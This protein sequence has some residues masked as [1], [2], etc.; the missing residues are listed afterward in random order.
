MSIETPPPVPPYQAN[1]YAAPAPSND[2]Y[3]VLAIVSLVTAFFVSLAA[4]IT[5]HIALSQIKKT[6]EKG[7]GLALAGLILGYLG[8]LGGIIATIIIIVAFATIGTTAKN[9]IDQGNAFASSLPTDLSSPTSSGPADASGQS[10]TEA[11]T[12]LESSLSS[13]TSGLTQGLNDIASNPTQAVTS[14]QAVADAFDAGVSQISNPRI[15][16]VATTADT[17]LKAMIAAVTQYI[18]DP[19]GGSGAVVSAATTVQSD[20]TAIGTACS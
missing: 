16:A 12:I 18:N 3:N 8:I 2:K 17:D 1:Q 6:G 13:S 19:S 9:A 11:C 14:L 7:R 5:G 20:F 10:T 4:V 15:L